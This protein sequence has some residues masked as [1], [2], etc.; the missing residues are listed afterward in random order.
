MDPDRVERDYETYRRL[1]DLWARENPVKTNK[2]QVLLLVNGLL[3]IAF[4][5][6]GGLV[7]ENRLISLGGFLFSLVWLLSIGRT[8]LFQKVWQAKLDA[9]AAR[10]SDDDRFQVLDTL[11]AERLAPGFLRLFGG[12]SSKYYLVVAPLVL[13]AAWLVAFL[14]ILFVADPWS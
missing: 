8:S 3:L 7:T 1:L 5:L 10:H 4:T 14:Y 6:N 12:V 13:C 11:E 2:L 9:L